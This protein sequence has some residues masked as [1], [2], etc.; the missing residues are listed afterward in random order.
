MHIHPHR[1]GHPAIEAVCRSECGANILDPPA[2]L[3]QGNLTIP[4]L[5]NAIGAR[6]EISSGR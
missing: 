4:Y 1:I 3:N 2:I 6:P 5:M